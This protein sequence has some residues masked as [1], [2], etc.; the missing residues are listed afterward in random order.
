MAKKS[1][2]PNPIGY[3]Q[4]S[5]KDAEGKE[6]PMII[7]QLTL[8][9]LQRRSQDI[10]TMLNAIR[11]AEQ[12]IPRRTEL[13][14]MYE[15]FLS[16]DAHLRT[17]KDKR[18][19]GVTNLDWM[20]QD[21]DGKEVQWVTDWIDT[22]DF[23]LVISELLNSKFWGYTMLE[24]EFY[25]DG[26]FGIYLVPRK[27]MRPSKGMISTE[28]TGD[29]GINI[30]EGVYADTILEA[31]NEKD[32]GL[33]ML[34]AQ[35]VIFKR[36]SL[37]D[38]AQFAEVFGQPLIDA[39]W[40]G[41]DETQRLGLLKSLEEMGGGGQIVRPAGTELTFLQGGSNNPTGEIFKGIYTVCNAEISKLFVGQT[42]TTE[43]SSSSGQAQATVHAGTEND[44]MK[45]DVKFVRRL[46]NKRLLNIL[47]TQGLLEPGGKFLVKDQD[48]EA[49]PTIIAAKLANDVILKNTI[50]LP[51][52]DDYFYETYG[53]EK[54][55][56][57]EEQKAAQ[58][59]K[60]AAEAAGGGFNMAQLPDLIVKLREAGLFLKAPKTTGA[61][62]KASLN[63][64]YSMD[65]CCGSVPRVTIKLAG[66]KPTNDDFIK[67]IFK[68][69]LKSGQ[70]HD[71]YYFDVAKKLSQA[72]AEGIGVKSFS[73]DDPRA[74][75]FEKFRNNVYAFSAAKSL[76]MLQE[77]SKA[78]KDDKG[79]ARSYN[80]FRDS[81]TDVGKEF[82]DAHLNSEYRSAVSMG[83]MGNK[84]QKL[85]KYD[86]LTYR[87]VGDNKVRPKH[88]QLDGTTLP[89]N[90]PLWAKIYPPNDWGDR[91][92]VIPAQGA[93]QMNR[94]IAHQFSES[95][96]LKP[97]FKKNAGIDHVA[98]NEDEHP[99]FETVKQFKTGVNKQ[100]E[101]MA[102]KNYNMQ[103]VESILSKKGLPEFVQA[104][105][106]EAALEQWNASSK[107]VKS[108]DGM[109]WD[110]TDRWDHVVDQHDTEERWKYINHTKDVLENADEVWMSKEK[111]ADGKVYTYKR[112]VKY[113]NDQP[114]VFSHPVEKPDNWTMYASSVDSSGTHKLLRDKAR[115]GVLIHRK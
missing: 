86:M 41:F 8:R 111:G 93:V 110:F 33:L 82:N 74:Q 60:K 75:L 14:D 113:Y 70:I 35:Y 65:G 24:V 67:K 45:S 58:A 61:D 108:A 49:D 34:A 92:T 100:V 42:E 55:A 109:S 40:D 52:N 23:E 71:G 89:T 16:S 27:H 57:Y 102:E 96:A 64:L 48:Q 29:A 39:V 104:S 83:Q 28:Q 31:G 32:L 3:N 115:R 36:G 47:E 1:E 59:A 19:M 90:D 94:D 79:E 101:L 37:S 26:T 85:Q 112:Y 54:P 2:T 13:Y 15:D 5:S 98:F 43:S 11:A 6:R 77:Y 10:A 17:V 21:K 72:I 7:Q 44:I 18:I 62:I 12:T 73:V 106:K 87:T 68:G 25:E 46:L 53:I 84:W 114:V 91:C 69:E 50:G 22:P 51:M 107:K 97:Y 81:V 56:D 99:Y 105:T 66:N 20:Y 78:L 80:K 95:P 88:A 4:Q 38:W 30:R 103:P 63:K 9:P 76:T